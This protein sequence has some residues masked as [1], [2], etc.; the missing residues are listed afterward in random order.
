MVSI[1]V[2]TNMGF[3]YVVGATP[4]VEFASLRL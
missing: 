1:A 4:A 3:G 2:V